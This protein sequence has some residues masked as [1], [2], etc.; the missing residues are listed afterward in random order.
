MNDLSPLSTWLYVKLFLRKIKGL[1]G[2]C[3]DLLWFGLR[4][5]PQ[6]TVGS[7]GPGWGFLFACSVLG[8]G[9]EV[10]E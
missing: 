9:P 3:R 7:G 2:I 5:F 4:L 6:L 8:N 1:C 10:G